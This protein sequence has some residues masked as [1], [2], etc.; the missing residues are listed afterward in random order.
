MKRSQAA[1]A[2]GEIKNPETA[3]ALMELLRD[4]DGTVRESVVLALWR[5]G[6]PE[7]A[8]GL[9]QALEDADGLI[10]SRAA[11]ALGEINAEQAVEPL[12]QLAEKDSYARSAAAL[13][14]WKISPLKSVKPLALWAADDGTADEAITALTQLLEQAA[15]AVA[16]EDLQAVVQLLQAQGTAKEAGRGGL[17]KRA[18]PSTVCA[19][20]QKELARRST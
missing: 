1:R 11:R 13:A 5:I 9:T 16:V 7:A 19:L 12:L 17:V 14:I 6:G 2:L 20:A 3:P 8:T 15:N 4:A 10:R 18:D